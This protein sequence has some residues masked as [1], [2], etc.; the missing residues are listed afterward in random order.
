MCAPLHLTAIG[1]WAF[2]KTRALALLYPFYLRWHSSV[3]RSM[4]MYTCVILCVSACVLV[5]ATIDV[6]DFLLSAPQKGDSFPLV[7][8]KSP[9]SKCAV[10]VC[11]RVCTRENMERTCGKRTPSDG[12][13]EHV[14]PVMCLCIPCV[15]CMRGNVL[16]L[17]SIE[18]NGVLFLPFSISVAI[19]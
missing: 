6:F 4:C 18:L 13:V 16:V 5:F 8:D 19:Q 3:Y 7:L 2:D 12:C 11:V 1:T 15:V 14:A 17:E 10:C 9:H